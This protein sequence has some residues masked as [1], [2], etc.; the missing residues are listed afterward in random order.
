MSFELPRQ[1]HETAEEKKLVVLK[2]LNDGCW[3]ADTVERNRSESQPLEKHDHPAFFSERSA[4]FAFPKP[5]I[6]NELIEEGLIEVH[7]SPW[8]DGDVRNP[9][10]NLRHFRITDRGKACLDSDEAL[11]TKSR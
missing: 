8:V 6:L 3:L 10:Y 9:N 7:I 5:Q 11:R 1:H 2:Y 4:W